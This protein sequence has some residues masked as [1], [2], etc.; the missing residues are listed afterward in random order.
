MRNKKKIH[1]W[2]VCIFVFVSIGVFHI[3][4]VRPLTRGG[5]IPWVFMKTEPQICTLLDKSLLFHSLEFQKFTQVPKNPG[6]FFSF[7]LMRKTSPQSGFPG[8]NSKIAN[9]F[10]VFLTLSVKHWIWVWGGGAIKYMWNSLLVCSI[11]F[12][13]LIV[14]R[15]SRGMIRVNIVREVSYR[16]SQDE[17]AD[18]VSVWHWVHDHF[19]WA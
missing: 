8:K 19:R 14:I 15:W 10:L 6:F 5:W 11:L 3:N 7:L 13:E 16:G 18:W 12:G 1:G 2:H 9:G 4:C 17:T